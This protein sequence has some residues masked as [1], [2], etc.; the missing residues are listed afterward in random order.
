M[1]PHSLKY[2]ILIACALCPLA[3][4]S[5]TLAASGDVYDLGTLGGNKKSVR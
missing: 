2:V 3:N 1:S 4:P 5:M